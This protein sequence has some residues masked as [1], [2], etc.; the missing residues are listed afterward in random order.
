MAARVQYGPY[1]LGL[2][3]EVNVWGEDTRNIIARAGDALA[4]FQTLEGWT[5]MLWLEETLGGRPVR[6]R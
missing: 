4:A 5:R 1:I 3:E 2:W 6:E